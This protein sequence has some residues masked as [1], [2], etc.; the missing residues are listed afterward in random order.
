M[1]SAKTMTISKMDNIL[2]ADAHG[3]FF[4]VSVS[5]L[6]NVVWT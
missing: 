1:I 2:K 6:C 3:T 4:G 5:V